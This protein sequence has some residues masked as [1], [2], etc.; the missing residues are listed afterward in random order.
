MVKYGRP[1]MA[2]TR[3]I[4]GFT[5]TEVILVLVLMSALA[6]IAIPRWQASGFDAA[7]FHE[8]VVVTLR[9]AQRQAVISGCAVAARLQDNTTT[10]ITLTYQVI[11]DIGHDGCDNNDMPHPHRGGNYVI[12]APR[13][14]SLNFNSLS[15]IYFHP[16]G[17]AYDDSANLLEKTTFSVAG[18]PVH[19]ESSG[20]VH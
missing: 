1:V 19:I 15:V 20:Y 14:V 18:R 4:R 12:T 5:L 7:Y 13:G 2:S 8:E 3:L 9:Y 11:E 16:D 10:T 17:R 6:V